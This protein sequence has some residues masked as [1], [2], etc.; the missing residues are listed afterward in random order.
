VK[1]C[2]EQGNSGK[3]STAHRKKNCVVIRSITQI[4]Q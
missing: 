4:M 2:N 1:E 3:F